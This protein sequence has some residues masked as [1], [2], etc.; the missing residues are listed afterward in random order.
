[1]PRTLLS[2]VLISCAGAANAAEPLHTQIDALVE[3]R[4]K[5]DG[6]PLSAPANDAEFVR[7]AYLDFAGRI[8]TSDEA[9]AF[10]ADGTADKRAKLIDALLAAPEYAP[11]MADL[12]HVM[13][14][15]RL[16]DNA[17]WTK[18]LRESFAAN[19][20]WDAMVRKML[21][22]DPKDSARP[23]AAF[24]L[25]KRLENY[26]QNPVDYSGLTRDV[27]R[28]FL[29]KNLQCCECHDHLT[30]DDYKQQHFQG[31]H[32]FFKNAYLANAAKL[33]VGERPTTE[34]TPFASVF[35]KVPMSTA[36]ALPGLAMLEIPASTKG[37]EF[38]EQPDKKTGSP[39]VLK[40]SPLKEISERLPTR[41][42]AD[43]ARNSA[44]RMW[45][46]LTGRGIVHPLDLHHSG[47]PPSHPELLDLLAKEFVA[48]D[49][50]I[51][52]LLREIAL[53]RTYARSGKLPAG[54]MEPPH[55][56]YFATALERRLT[57]EQLLQ[58]VIVA[59]GADSKSADVLRPKYVRA[60]ANQAREPEEEVTPSLKAALFVLHDEAV[61]GLLKPAPNNLVGRATKLSDADAT[62][63]LY[64]AIL[65]RK[66]SD[67]ERA[68]V[69]KMLAKHPDK[70]SE[71]LGRVAW[72]LLASMEFGVNH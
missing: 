37:A 57:A 42:N 61:L 72:A 21:R 44:N 62:D 70:R 28:L 38:V 52:W 35:T 33:I 18:F 8:P 32:S 68:A 40:F 53:T 16:G 50:D 48:H 46:L 22:A 56:K 67:E 27:G 25:A 14:M 55:A 26:G 4:A 30:V 64:L 54:A 24:W 71:S 9:R 29:G 66:P 3:A 34:K 20:K 6:M 1:M 36:P 11:R 63:S 58:S 19:A 51:K 59:T 12:F 65:S 45:F 17:E 23:G 2:L 31:L 10:L 47:N 69:R 7:R 41:A 39:G 15:E 60:F 43:F 49:F 5:A 13:L